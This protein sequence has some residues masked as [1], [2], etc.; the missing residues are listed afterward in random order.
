MA[1]FFSDPKKR[2]AFRAAVFKKGASNQEKREAWLACA[3]PWEHAAIIEAERAASAVPAALFLLKHAAKLVDQLVP[4][5][6]QP[7]G[8]A[9]VA[10]EECGRAV[11]QPS[12]RWCAD[13]AARVFYGLLNRTPDAE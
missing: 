8:E 6:P 2:A 5:D 4:D 7:P 3:A 9:P 1:V 10:C 13:C 12:H 11:D